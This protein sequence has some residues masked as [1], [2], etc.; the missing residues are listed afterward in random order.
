LSLFLIV[1]EVGRGELLFDDPDF[2]LLALEVKESLAVEEY[3]L[4]YFQPDRLVRVP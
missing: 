4:E 1:P 2:R 3:A